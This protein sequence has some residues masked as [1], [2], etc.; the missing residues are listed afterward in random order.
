M[1][2][3]RIKRKVIWSPGST[4]TSSVCAR[5]APSRWTA[6]SAARSTSLVVRDRGTRASTLIPP[7]SIRRLHHW[8]RRV[9]GIC[10]IALGES[11]VDG[12]GA[13]SWAGLRSGLARGSFDREFKRWPIVIGLKRFGHR[14]TPRDGSRRVRV[15]WP[16]TRA[17]RAFD[18]VRP[19]SATRPAVG[20]N[21]LCCS[22]QRR[23]VRR[24]PVTRQCGGRPGRRRSFRRSGKVARQR[25]HVLAGQCANAQSD[26][27]DTRGL[28]L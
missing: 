2:M 1:G 26:A 15:G 20:A 10:R 5:S 16:R 7:L 6:F 27:R 25:N 11:R 19:K 21:V 8:R 22:A 14:A 3:E 9:R 17:H 23:P 4:D 18:G 13:H 28:A 12:R 24:R